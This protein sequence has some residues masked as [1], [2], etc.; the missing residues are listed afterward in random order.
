MVMTDAK[1][2]DVA[3]IRTRYFESGQGEVLVLV[4]GGSS[5]SHDELVS[6][7]EDWSLNFEGLTRWFHVYALDK[8]GQGYTENPKNLEG[9]SRAGQMEHLYEFL[10][11]LGLKEINLVGHSEG[12]YMVARLALEH[13]E[14]VKSCT[15]VDSGNLAPGVGRPHLVENPPPPHLSEESMRWVLERY[16]YSYDHITKETLEGM[17]RV[18]MLP[19]YQEAVA[20]MKKHGLKYSQVIPQKA[21]QKD[22]TL[23]WILEGRLKTPT[24][25]AWGYNDPTALVGMGQALFDLIAGSAPQAEMHIFNQAGHYVFREHPE[26]FNRVVRSFIAPP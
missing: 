5:A 20:T 1:F 22:E 17:C 12:G 16:S 21:V 11:T 6:Y 2:V 13:P 14:L 4:H 19:K 24:L 10:H 23:R 9:Y 26:E 15:I 8:L 18:A 3:G 7:A 25:V